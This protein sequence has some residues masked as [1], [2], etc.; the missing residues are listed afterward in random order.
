VKFYFL[1]QVLPLRLQ[2]IKIGKG[3]WAC[4]YCGRIMNQ[5]WLMRR[6]I[7]S[8]TG[9]KPFSC[10]FCPYSTIQ[11]SNLKNHVKKSHG[12]AA[13]ADDS[14]LVNLPGYPRNVP[15]AKAEEQQLVGHSIFEPNIELAPKV[16]EER[17]E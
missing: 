16:K 9:D 17:S 4:P 8:H 6:H 11:K 2:P 3:N 15:K 12:E 10:K 14:D 5:G 1:F 13:V 7:K